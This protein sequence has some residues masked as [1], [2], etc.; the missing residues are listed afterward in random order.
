MRGLLAGLLTGLVVG[1]VAAAAHRVSGPGYPDSVRTLAYVT[2]FASVWAGIAF[3]AGITVPRRWL[4]ATSG[5]LALLVAV[6]G[7]YL[8]DMVIGTRV[9]A[10]MAWVLP[11]M[12]RWCAIAVPTGIVFGL[13]G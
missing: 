11:T 3:V 12:V 8:V 2:N 6:V 5:V 7:Y 4:A 9:D 1:V 13:L 10:P